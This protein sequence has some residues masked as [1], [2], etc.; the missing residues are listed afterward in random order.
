MEIGV[1]VTRDVTPS[2]ILGVVL[3]VAVTVIVVLYYER[4]WVLERL[5]G[6]G[7][8]RAFGFILMAL[9]VSLVIAGLLWTEFA[10]IVVAGFILVALGYFLAEKASE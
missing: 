3:M 8:L 2:A 1:E 10:L 7:I 5:E 4:E 6:L 9:G